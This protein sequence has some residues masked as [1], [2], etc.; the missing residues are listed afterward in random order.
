V[1]NQIAQSI[2]KGLGSQLLPP[3]VGSLSLTRIWDCDHR[4]N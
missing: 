3:K 4:L 2:Y 1:G